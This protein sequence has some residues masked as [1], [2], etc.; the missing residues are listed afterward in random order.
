MTPE[1]RPAAG[2]LTTAL[3]TAG[4]VGGSLIATVSL[5]LAFV[6][7]G[8]DLARHAN[9]M[10][11]LGDWGW[12]QTVNFIVCGLLLIAFGAGIWRVAPGVRAGRAAAVC[13]V[14]YGLLAGVVVGLNPTDP[15]FGFPPGAPQGYPGAEGLSTSAKIHGVAGGLGFLAATVGCFA[16]ARYFAYL[17]DRFWMAVS[18][19]VGVAVLAVGG[20][21][22]LNADAQTD[23]FNYVPAWVSGAALWLFIVAVAARLLH[24]HRDAHV[25]TE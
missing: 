24:S 8:F 9:S 22:G 17:G 12:I 14:L 6:R 4:V 10:L 20:Y 23:A 19:V 1:A 7:P 11:V 2:R 15:G 18:V 13:M 3:L 25:G 21:L 5:T 16:L